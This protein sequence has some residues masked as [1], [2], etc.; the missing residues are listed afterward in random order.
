MEALGAV[1][2]VAVACLV[3][4]RWLLTFKA[5]EADRERLHAMDCMRL[6]A[7]SAGA[8]DVAE[9]SKRLAQ[10]EAWRDT[11]ALRSIRG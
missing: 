8:K 11:Q 9:L 5:R 7:E 2:V 1:A 3:G 6:G 10:L 4:L